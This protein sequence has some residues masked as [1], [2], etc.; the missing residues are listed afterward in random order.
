MRKRALKL[1]N[2]RSCLMSSGMEGTQTRDFLPLRT[3]LYNLLQKESMKVCHPPRRVFLPPSEDSLAE[4]VVSQ[5][6]FFTVVWWFSVISESTTSKVNVKEIERM[7]YLG[8]FSTL[9]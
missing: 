4:V 1:K 2:S 5:V 7:F 9:S 8:H 3:L 6:S